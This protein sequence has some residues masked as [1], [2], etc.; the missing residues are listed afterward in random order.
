MKLGRGRPWPA[1]KAVC[2]PRRGPRHPDGTGL[3][4]LAGVLRICLSLNRG[5]ASATP[6]KRCGRVRCGFP[7]RRGRDAFRAPTERSTWSR[8]VPMR[9][10]DDGR[11][12]LPSGA[13]SSTLMRTKTEQFF[14]CKFPFRRLNSQMPSSEMPIK[15]DKLFMTAKQDHFPG[16]FW[17]SYTMR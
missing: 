5:G 2:R 13:E 10:P 8:L 6:N 11:R 7:T 3:F 16:P 1:G 4:L 12:I 15:D 17:R 14:P 9:R